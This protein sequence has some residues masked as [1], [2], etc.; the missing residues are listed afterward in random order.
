MWVHLELEICIYEIFRFPDFLLD[1]KTNISK[2][3]STHIAV[4]VAINTV[5]KSQY[6]LIGG[7][8]LS[9]SDGRMTKSSDKTIPVSSVIDITASRRR[10]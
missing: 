9:T 5:S 4:T 7:I 6:S 3:S 10:S 1:S 2:S 8:H